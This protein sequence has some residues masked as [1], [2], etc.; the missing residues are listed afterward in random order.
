[1]DLL[2]EFEKKKVNQIHFNVDY[3]S[4]QTVYPDEL[5]PQ[6]PN[7]PQQPNEHHPN[8]YVQPNPPQQ[9]N[10]LHPNPPMQPNPPNIIKQGGRDSEVDR[11][12][13]F[14]D[15]S[16]GEGDGLLDVNEENVSQEVV[17]EINSDEDGDV[18]QPYRCKA[19]M[20]DG[21]GRITLEVGQL[22]R[23]M[24]HFR[25]V[26]LDYSIPTGFQLNRI[27]NEK[28]RITFGCL[29][30][31]CLWRVHGSPIDGK[32]YM[33]KTLNNEHN[34][35]AVAKNK[36]VTSSWIRK[37]F[38]ILIKENPQMNIQVLHSVVLRACGV[39]GPDHTLYRA[40][41]YALNIGSEDQNVVIINCTSTVFALRKGILELLSS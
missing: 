1:M 18:E 8:P 20:L 10:V 30:D 19:F 15:N 7:P 9:A 35:L 2:T 21:D 13:N 24:T 41:R 17:R 12:N 5:I 33:L 29:T 39:N 31:G 11:D 40:K 25:Q 28:I 14:K 23:N 6:Q 32:T 38:K 36:E 16:E 3:L 26:I 22:Y 27:K 34:C 37:R 4:V